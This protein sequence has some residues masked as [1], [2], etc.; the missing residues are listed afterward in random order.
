M[1]RYILILVVSFASI[2]QLFGVE[3]IDYGNKATEIILNPL[4]LS[5]LTF[6]HKV[7]RLSGNI[8][9]PEEILQKP[10]NNR[11]QINAITKEEYERVYGKSK[12]KYKII[13]NVFTRLKT[14]QL[15]LKFD[16]NKKE[17]IFQI[18]DEVEKTK[19][20]QA[21]QDHYFYRAPDPDVLHHDEL[22]V[23]YWSNLGE[24]PIFQTRSPDLVA[25]DTMIEGLKFYPISVTTVDKWD[26]FH[27][28]LSFVSGRDWKISSYKINDFRIFASRP[29]QIRFETDDRSK[30]TDSVNVYYMFE[31]SSF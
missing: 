8:Y 2:T 23:M 11:F 17:S 12:S 29:G 7:N 28:V 9:K 4:I 21:D 13:L 15:L 26:L 1:K 20:S 14:Y 27:G 30:K 22:F 31:R 18:I 5:E 16:V 25:Y 10:V 19:Y 6:P 3:T 24:M